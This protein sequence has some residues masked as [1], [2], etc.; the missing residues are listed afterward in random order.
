MSAQMDILISMKANGDAVCAASLYLAINAEKTV[1]KIT[2][3]QGGGQR[4]GKAKINTRVQTWI[5]P[6]F[7]PITPNFHLSLTR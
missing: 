4:G 2:P 6:F 5:Q 1:I 3:C 7:S